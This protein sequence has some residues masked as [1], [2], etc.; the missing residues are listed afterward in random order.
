MEAETISKNGQRMKSQ[1]S[2]LRFLSF[3]IVVVFASVTFVACK[4]ENKDDKEKEDVYLLVEWVNDYGSTK[5][6][7]DNQNRIT[8]MIDDSDILTIT[9]NAAGDV[10][11]VQDESINSPEYSHTI[12]FTKNGNDITSTYDD[13]TLI[14]IELNAEGLPIKWLREE[15]SHESHYLSLRTYQWQNGNMVRCDYEDKYND[16]TNSYTENLTYDDKKNPMLYCKTPKWIFSTYIAYRCLFGNKNNLIS[17]DDDKITYT[18]NEAG[19]PVS[20]SK[21]HTYKYEKK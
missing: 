16:L 3:F 8:K 4:K 7:Y 19:L 1:M 6:E 18:Y 9:Y 17:L 2:R 11:S 21:G 15:W 5:F 14:S 20:D 12:M 13:G 10:V